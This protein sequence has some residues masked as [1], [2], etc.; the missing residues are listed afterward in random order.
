MI[1]IYVIDGCPFCYKSKLLLKTLKIRFKE[2]N[3]KENEK[4]KY[5]KMN[6]M[7]TFPQIFYVKNNEKLKIGGFDELEFLISLVE[8]KKKFN[9]NNKIINYFEKN[10]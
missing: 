7:N 5:K 6:K 4:C 2:I 3:V 9:F 1:N 8:I 10:I